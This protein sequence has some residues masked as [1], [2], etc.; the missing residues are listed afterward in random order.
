[1][2]MFMLDH[3]V[4]KVTAALEGELDLYDR[5]WFVYFG[6]SLEFD[7]FLLRC[8]LRVYARRLS[9]RT[10]EDAVRLE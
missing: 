1:M 4:D 8:E 6:Q 2:M 9:E 3:L 5:G 10:C 7:Y